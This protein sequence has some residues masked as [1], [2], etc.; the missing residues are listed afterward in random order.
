[1]PVLRKAMQLSSNLRKELKA[2]GLDDKVQV[3]ITGCFG[4]CEKGPIV[5]VMPDNTFYYP[6]KPEDAQDNCRGTR[7]QR[8]K[9]HQAFI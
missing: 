6:G 7:Y 2:K 5:K 1:M 9:S 8:P 4:F 3:I